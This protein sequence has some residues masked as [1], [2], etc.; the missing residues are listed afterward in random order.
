MSPTEPAFIVPEEALE[1]KFLAST[2]PGGQNVNKVATAVQLRCDVFKLGLAP[3][4]YQRLKEL[5]GSRMTGDGEI[6][7]TARTHRTQDA[8]REEARA[9]LADL[10]ARAHV[11][12][13][14]RVKTKPSRAAK[15]RRVDE[16]KGRGTVKAGRRKVKLD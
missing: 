8:N 5:A 15:A 11:R 2:G 13:A 1:E 3:H 9:R 16:K 6:I 14:R 10:I 4:V 7:I 12:Q